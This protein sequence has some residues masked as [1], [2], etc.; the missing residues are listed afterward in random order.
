M[1]NIN[2]FITVMLQFYHYYYCVCIFK[3]F[4]Q[5]LMYFNWTIMNKCKNIFKKHHQILNL[6]LTVVILIWLVKPFTLSINKYWLGS[7]ANC[8]VK[9]MFFHC[10]ILSGNW[11][12]FTFSFLLYW[13][14]HSLLIQFFWLITNL[15]IR[16]ICPYKRYFICTQWLLSIDWYSH[17]HT[18]KHSQ[19]TL[20]Y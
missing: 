2:I 19:L 3:H 10:I 9:L 15:D 7:D 5:R 4:S 6:I 17:T 18:K 20:I 11:F 12:L 1:I 16:Y 13:L 14:I 8:Q